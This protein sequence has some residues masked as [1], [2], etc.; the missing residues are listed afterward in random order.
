QESKFSPF[1]TLYSS[2]GKLIKTFA[3]SGLYFIPV[4]NGYDNMSV[5]NVVQQSDKRFI[6]AGTVF[7]I[8]GNRRELLLMRLN[9]EQYPQ[10][11]HKN[12]GHNEIRFDAYPN[13]A[14]NKVVINLSTIGNKE[15]QVFFRNSLGAIVKHI[16]TS[17]AISD[18]L[19][20]DLP[21]GTYFISVHT[22]D[23]MSAT[24]KLIVQ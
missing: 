22:K 9:K 17:R 4:P 14:S 21:A 12:P 2:D 11:I 20:D 19:I 3:D 16:K 10:S 24:K 1:V 15:A 6:L 23:G 7:N 8:Q 18:V 13:P 5:F